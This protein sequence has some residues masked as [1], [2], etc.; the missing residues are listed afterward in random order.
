MHV[1]NHKLCMT[2]LSKVKTTDLDWFWLFLG[3]MLNG[4]HL[5]GCMLSAFLNWY[6]WLA[7]YHGKKIICEA[8]YQRLIIY[9]LWI[10]ISCCMLSK[11]SNC[12]NSDYS[13]IIAVSVICFWKVWGYLC[14][15]HNATYIFN[16]SRGWCRFDLFS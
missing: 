7:C 1:Q 9:I 16:S 13:C 8:E 4:I 3:E 6:S 10:F 11:I 15:M 12:V 2:T 14:D 5:N